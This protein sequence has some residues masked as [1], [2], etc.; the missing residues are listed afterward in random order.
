MSE[1]KDVA[2]QDLSGLELLRLAISRPEW[3]PG[4]GRLLGMTF[5]SVHEGRVVMS[6][7]SRP[8]FANPLGTVHG[9]VH[10]TLLDSVMSCAVHSVLPAGASYT[11]LELKVNFVSAVRL[12]GERLVGEGETVHVGGRTATAEGRITDTDGRLVAHGT[13]TCL[14]FR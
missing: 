7:L 11:T 9:G 10:A 8:D 1:T 13:T 14:V 12:D 2:W 5:D 6:V 3:Q 4:F